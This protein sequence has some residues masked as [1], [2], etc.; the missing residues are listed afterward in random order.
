MPGTT[1]SE[2]W[3]YVTPVSWADSYLPDLELVSETP[4]REAGGDLWYK[5]VLRKKLR[6]QA[7]QSLDLGAR[8][9]ARPAG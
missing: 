8:S 1:E 9:M 5:W 2:T 4:Y 3:E 6:C 7:Q